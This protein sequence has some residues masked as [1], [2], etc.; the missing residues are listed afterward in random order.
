[1]ERDQSLAADFMSPAL[2]LLHKQKT[3]AMLKKHE[4]NVLKDIRLLEAHLLGLLDFQDDRK[5]QA[6]VLIKGSMIDYTEDDRNGDIIKGK[7]DK[8]ETFRELWTFVRGEK[9]WVVDKIQDSP[10]LTTTGFLK[11]W[12]EPKA[13]SRRKAR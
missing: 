8:D 7:S 4:R 10:E 1:M 11:A 5:D 9:D 13:A 6:S 3:D 2:F 12:R